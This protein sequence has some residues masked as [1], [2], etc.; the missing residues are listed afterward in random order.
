MRV[1]ISAPLNFFACAT[2]IFFPSDLKASGNQLQIAFLHS[3]MAG[4]M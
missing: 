1:S 2:M 3:A 4:A